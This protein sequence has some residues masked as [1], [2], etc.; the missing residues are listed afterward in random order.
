MDY[1]PELL[2][3]NIHTLILAVLESGAL[4]GYAISKEIAARS[5]EAL[6]FGEGTI[7]PALKALERE[8]F[9]E[10]VWEHPP[11]GPARKVYSLTEP[12]RYELARRRDLWNS[13]VQSIDKVIGG[14]PNVQP[15]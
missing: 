6:A 9:I 8:G 1:G 11:S 2:K 12:G 4:H 15:I 7:Y 5:Q 3:G 14:N 10:G 13:F